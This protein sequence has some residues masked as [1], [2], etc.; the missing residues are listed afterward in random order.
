MLEEFPVEAPPAHLP[1]SPR[2][3]LD[4]FVSEAE[5]IAQP[6]VLDVVGNLPLADVKIRHSPVTPPH[7]SKTLTRGLVICALLGALALATVTWRIA[8]T[9]PSATTRIEPKSERAAVPFMQPTEVVETP[10]APAPQER[11]AQIAEVAAPITRMPVQPEPSRRET[12]PDTTRRPLPMDSAKPS[13]VMAAP[14]PVVLEPLLDAPQPALVPAAVIAPAPASVERV[15]HAPVPSRV[16]IDREAIQNVLG[17][18]RAAYADLDARAV[19]QVWP[20]ASE[21]ALAKAF[22][23]LESQDVAFYG[24]DTT[25]SVETARAACE[26]QV[27]YVGRVGPRQPRT[28]DREW[29]FTLRKVEGDRWQIDRVQVR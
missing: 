4:G 24:C 9:P 20:S 1:K 13:V 5:L 29:T 11:P 3:P 17:Q 8:A 27:S 22:A 26:G 23:N 15:E 2:A 16:A 19:K 6:L 10:P 14:S 12:V 28:Q 7:R 21:A 18:F 25:I